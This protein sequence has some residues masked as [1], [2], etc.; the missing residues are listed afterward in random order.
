[1]IIYG[2]ILILDSALYLI[3]Y[4]IEYSSEN[5]FFSEHGAEPVPG[6]EL[7]TGA[8]PVLGAEIGTGGEPVLGAEIGTGAEPVS[9]AELGAPGSKVSKLVNSVAPVFSLKTI[10]R[11]IT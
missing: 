8:E 5:R 9:G 7:G 1:M 2:L 3:E 6:A 11:E 10:L 4:L